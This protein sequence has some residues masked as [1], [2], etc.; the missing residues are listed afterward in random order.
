MR[1]QSLRAADLDIFGVPSFV[2]DGDLFWGN[3]RLVDALS[4]A[5]HGR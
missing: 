2:V 5:I 1:K 3:D 4:W